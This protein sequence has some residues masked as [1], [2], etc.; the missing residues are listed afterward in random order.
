[1]IE[2]RKNVTTDVDVCVC[3]L[4]MEITW[5]YLFRDFVDSGFVCMVFT[6][7]MGSRVYLPLKWSEA[8]ESKQTI[9]LYT[10]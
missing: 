2:Q 10:M 5:T 8:R 7:A 9:F 3:E 6:C 4:E 1:M